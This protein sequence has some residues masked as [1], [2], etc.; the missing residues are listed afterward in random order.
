MA[1]CVTDIYPG[2]DNIQVML[3]KF[4]HGVIY[5][6]Y[7]GQQCIEEI[8]YYNNQVNGINENGDDDPDDNPAYRLWSNEGQI[9]KEQFFCQGVFNRDTEGSSDIVRPAS[10]TWD[11]DG[12]ILVQ[13][14]YIKGRLHRN[15]G[16]ARITYVKQGDE[17]VKTEQFL[18][19]NQK[20]NT[21][22][23]IK[24]HT[25]KINNSLRDTGNFDKLPKVECSDENGI[26]ETRE[27]I[28]VTNA[29]EIYPGI[30]ENDCS[31]FV[32]RDELVYIQQG[33]GP[34]RLVNNKYKRFYF[35]PADD[36]VFWHRSSFM[37]H[38]PKTA[39]TSIIKSL[40]IRFYLGHMFANQ[41][42]K[43]VWSKL[44]TIVR[45]PYDRLV[46][47]YEFM[48]RGG[49]HY[50]WEYLLIRDRYRDFSD[51]VLYGLDENYN[52]EN[53]KYSAMETLIPQTEFLC[54]ENEIILSPENIGRFENLDLDCKRL[55]DIDSLPH[56]NHKTNTQHWSSYYTDDNV[57]LKVARLYARDFSMLGYATEIEQ[58]MET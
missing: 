52:Q 49:F 4:D 40:D 54:H 25:D 39:G 41:Y 20:Y 2:P 8:R 35:I 28:S 58:V 29:Q 22:E 44:K 13:G 55:F 6:K 21:L 38:I 33:P 46:S 1:N 34:A 11:K 3:I 50:N 27:N 24:I 32:A 47:A 56:Y 42:P 12:N 17:W 57:R 45:N 48:C 10:L 14:Y 18:C 37:V 23:E 31:S 7:I 43:H 16:P 15:D 19:H 51:W 30:T 9:L 53:D 36:S 26:N 5:R